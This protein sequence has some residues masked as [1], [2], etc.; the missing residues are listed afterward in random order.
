[1]RGDMRKGYR[2]KE[3]RFTY[4]ASPST[5]FVSIGRQAPL[6]VWGTLIPAVQIG[7]GGVHLHGN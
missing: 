1:M 4:L 5:R 7:G 3:K 2:N 6:C